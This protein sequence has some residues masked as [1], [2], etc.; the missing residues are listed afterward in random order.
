VE[1]D[2]CDIAGM[3]FECEEGVRVRG[4]DIVELDGVVACCGEET[5]VG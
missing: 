3:T 2:A 4:F 1:S 5:F